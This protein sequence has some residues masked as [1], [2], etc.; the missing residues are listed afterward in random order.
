M[1]YINGS[2]PCPIES[3]SLEYKLCT[4]PDNLFPKCYH[5]LSWWLDGT[6]AHIVGT[7]KTTK[8]A[9]ENLITTYANNSKTKIYGLH[10]T[11][12]NT[13]KDSKSMVEYLSEICI[14][15]DELYN[16]HK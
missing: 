15:V 2:Y 10:T 9:W 6:I 12:A 16:T 1:G 11:L 7:R 3:N 8:Q 5:G 14:I 4:I 13:N